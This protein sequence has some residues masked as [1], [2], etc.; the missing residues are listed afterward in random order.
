MIIMITFFI[1]ASS[2]LVMIIMIISVMIIIT[3][4]LIRASSGLVMIIMI[5]FLIRA[6][7]GSS[8]TA[9]AGSE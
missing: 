7:S 5:M 3:I 4:F 8:E 2:R 1:R 6:S 9:R